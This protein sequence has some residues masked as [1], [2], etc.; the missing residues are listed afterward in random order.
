MAVTDTSSSKFLPSLNLDSPHSPEL[1]VLLPCLSPLHDAILNFL[2]AIFT[3][4]HSEISDHIYNLW[5]FTIQINIDLWQPVFFLKQEF[6][7]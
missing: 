1:S 6:L 2:T 3:D 4:D 7:P 5:F